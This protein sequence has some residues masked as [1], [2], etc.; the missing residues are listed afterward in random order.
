MLQIINFQNLKKRVN[1]KRDTKTLY[2]TT[3]ALLWRHI[4]LY[5][6]YHRFMNDKKDWYYSPID[7]DDYV[8]SYVDGKEEFAKNFC[9]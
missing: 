9:I 3:K 1:K 4:N 7:I 8:K 2:K 6:R 5:D